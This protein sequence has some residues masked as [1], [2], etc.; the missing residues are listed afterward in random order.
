MHA[1]AAGRGTRPPR[2]PA[3]GG[4]GRHSR[5]DPPE[6]VLRVA[7]LRTARPLGGARKG[8]GGVRGDDGDAASRAQ[9]LPRR[10]HQGRGTGPEL[11]GQRRPEGAH[12]TW[13]HIKRAVLD[14]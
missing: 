6:A 13:G 11:P 10:L 9:A 2:P 7:R 4:P 3:R 14:A 1:G 12:S 8:A 5:G